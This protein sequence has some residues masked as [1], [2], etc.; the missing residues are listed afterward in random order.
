MYIY[1]LHRCVR[2][3]ALLHHP[4]GLSG[5][6]TCVGVV[7]GNVIKVVWVRFSRV[8]NRHLESVDTLFRQKS[9]DLKLGFV[10]FLNL[11]HHA[12]CASNVNIGAFAGSPTSG[13]SCRY[14]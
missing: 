14:T 13:V 12:P 1:L 11:S 8:L 5:F 10:H 3:R 6:S 9:L 4:L 7:A 2:P